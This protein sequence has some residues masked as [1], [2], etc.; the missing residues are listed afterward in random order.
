MTPPVASQAAPASSN[1][2]SADGTRGE[3]DESEAR[4]ATSTQDVMHPQDSNIVILWGD[5]DESIL[6]QSYAPRLAWEMAKEKEQSEKFAANSVNDAGG[7]A[8]SIGPEDPPTQPPFPPYALHKKRSKPGKAGQENDKSRVT[9]PE[10]AET[11][12]GELV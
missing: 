4:S 2:D 12:M 8:S 5:Y 3:R 1:E 10:S 9:C 11:A 7:V 6:W